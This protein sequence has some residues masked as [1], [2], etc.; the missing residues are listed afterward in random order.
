MALP[1]ITPYSLPTAAELPQARGAWR[2][3]RDRVA[4]LVHDMQRYFLAAFDAGRGR[5]TSSPTPTGLRACCGACRNAA[6]GVPAARA[7]AQAGTQLKW[8]LWENL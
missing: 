2:P 3:Q 1:R 4:L 5:T 8:R 7:Q 6:R